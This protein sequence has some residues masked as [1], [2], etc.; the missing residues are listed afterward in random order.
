MGTTIT[1]PTTP[2]GSSTSPVSSG[3]S[4]APTAPPSRASQAFDEL[5]GLV[6]TGSDFAFSPPV[7]IDEARQF[8]RLYTVGNYVLA[9]VVRSIGALNV[10]LNSSTPTG[11]VG[12]ASSLPLLNKQALVDA[13]SANIDSIIARSADNTRNE[14]Q[15]LEA[16]RS[17]FDLGTAAAP[18]V[19]IAFKTAFRDFV[20]L[21][22]NDL[23][24]VDPKDEKVNA[25]L[26]MDP[27]RIEEIY[28]HL[29]RTKRSLIHLV[30][31]MS[32]AGTLGS[33]SLVEKWARL[34]KDSLAVLTAVKPFIGDDDEDRR[35][36]W[37]VMAELNRVPKAQI[38]A[39]VVHA[40][41]GGQL[42]NDAIDVYGQLSAAQLN[43][44]SQVLLRDFFFDTAK[45]GVGG[46]SVSTLL[47]R[48]AQLIQENWIP[49][50]A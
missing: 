46:E 19:N 18:N 27:R 14:G 38:D 12:A 13:Q 1:I 33:S 35:H 11:A 49:A 23:M 5:M 9:G 32:A 2:T 34:V 21:C 48:N 7:N 15:L 31:T 22:A 24:G 30:E 50:W 43:D 6:T 45:F 20:A 16:V 39:Y 26:T 3:G 37:S 29:K 25:S 42:L 10:I 47:R 40:R 36:V 44:E 41:E 8:R 28:T 17:Q 4:T